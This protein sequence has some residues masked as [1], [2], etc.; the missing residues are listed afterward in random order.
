M[1]SPGCSKL[2][3]SALIKALIAFLGGFFLMSEVI[4]VQSMWML[5]STGGKKKLLQ[6]PP[7]YFLSLKIFTVQ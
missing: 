1:L 2:D 6:T 7:G 5:F 3:P 4:P